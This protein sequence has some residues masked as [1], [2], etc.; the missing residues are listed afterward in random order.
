MFLKYLLTFLDTNESVGIVCG[1][2]DVLRVIKFVWQLLDIVFIAVPIGLILIIMVDFAKNVMAGREDDM[3][4]N[5]NLVIKRLIFCVALFLVDPIVHF[6]I[7]LLGD[8]EVDFAKCIEIAFED[9]LSQYEINYPEDD[10]SD[11]EEPDYSNGGGYSVSEGSSS[12]TS[13]ITVKKILEAAKKRADYIRENGFTYGNATTNPAINDSE[14]LV[15]CDRFVG[16]VL[17]DLGYTDQPTTSGLVVYNKNS[18][19]HDFP[20]WCEKH[21]FKKIENI[22][23]VQAGDIIFQNM[24]S[25][26]GAHMYIL[27]N[28]KDGD[29]WERY[30]AGSDERIKSVQ[31]SVEIINSTRSFSFAYRIVD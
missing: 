12:S 5:L 14:K 10:F 6:A 13:S 21:G 8:Q 9:D 18:P 30:D 27:G 15:S 16:W 17:Y 19:E 24:T 7:D 29:N 4:K 26:F 25:G 31:P 11:R 1:G 3:K 20:T 23:D 22:E 2:A 28:K